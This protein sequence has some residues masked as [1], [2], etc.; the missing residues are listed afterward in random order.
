MLIVLLGVLF[1]GSAPYSLAS[2]NKQAS[3]YDGGT[4]KPLFQRPPQSTQKAPPSASPTIKTPTR[5]ALPRFSL[6]PS[7]QLVRLRFGVYPKWTRIVLDMT[8]TVPYTV[9]VLQNPPR[10]VV[11][12]PPTTWQANYKNNTMQGNGQGLVK[13]FRAGSVKNATEHNPN[14]TLD[15]GRYRLVFD[16]KT[17]VQLVKSFSIQTTE[18]NPARLVLDLSPNPMDTESLKQTAELTLQKIPPLPKAQG[19]RPPRPINLEDSEGQDLEIELASISDG[20]SASSIQSI[21]E[22]M[23]ASALVPLPTAKPKRSLAVVVLDAGHGGID[24]GATAVD[25][26]YE[27]DITLLMAKKLAA[28]LQE[29]GRYTVYLTRDTDTFIPLAKRV[30]IA[31]SKGAQLFISLHADSIDKEGVQG[32]SIYT[33]S[34][35]ASDEA[36]EKLAARENRSDLIAGVNLTDEGADVANILIDLALRESMNESKHFAQLAV[37]TLSAQNIRLLP[38]THRSAG[39][40]VLKAPDVPSVLIELGYLSNAADV[41]RLK[42]ANHQQQLIEALHYSIDG[43]F[44]RLAL[45]TAN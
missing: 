11:E 39:F 31:R 28:K 5:Q 7:T 35:N 36:S 29:S 40:A 38:N 27:K 13:A 43:Y 18:G 19:T 25:G 15:G 22:A 30:E 45:L 24:P 26:T 17:N 10:V 1:L 8:E 3:A 41:S 44:S 34:Q 16:M 23:P 14:N 20:R 32:L 9:N 37:N 4:V 33:L 2:E 6:P 21:S 42:D 12:L